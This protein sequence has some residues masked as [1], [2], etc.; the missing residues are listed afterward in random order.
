M[1]NRDRNPGEKIFD[2]I[3]SSPEN[4]LIADFETFFVRVSELSIQNT[5]SISFNPLPSRSSKNTLEYG[6]N[7]IKGF[8]FIDQR[9]IPSVIHRILIDLQI[10]KVFFVVQRRTLFHI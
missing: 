9:E 5:P 3:I 8:F 7:Y 1:P 2:A 6:V 4:Y 10:V